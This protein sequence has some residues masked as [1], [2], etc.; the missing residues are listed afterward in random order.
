M[1]SRT[2]RMKSLIGVG[3]LHALRSLK[4]VDFDRSLGAGFIR[5]PRKKCSAQAKASGSKLLISCA[6]EYAVIQN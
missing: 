6:I 4:D 1:G 5:S 3:V 2:L